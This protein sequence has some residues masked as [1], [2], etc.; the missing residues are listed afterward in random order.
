MKPENKKFL[1]ENMHHW[2]TLRD[3]QYLR[4]LNGQEREGMQ[5][6]MAEEFQPGYTADLY[7]PACCMEMVKLLYTRYEAWKIANEHAINTSDNL[8]IQIKANFPL[9]KKD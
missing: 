2:I 6:V 1:E 3:A 8:S 5:R 9:H 4:G 7:C